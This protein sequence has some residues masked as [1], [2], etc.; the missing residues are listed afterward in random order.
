MIRVLA[1][2]LAF[3]VA[4]PAAAEPSVAAAGLTAMIRKGT[5]SLKE[6]SWCPT[7]AEDANGGFLLHATAETVRS[8]SLNYDNLK[9]VCA[10]WLAA[11][12]KPKSLG[13]LLVTDQDGRELQLS[14]RCE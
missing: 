10:I 11:G 2:L 4:V 13:Y 3:A 6:Q 1:T 8:M 14:R 5:C 7:Y 12:G 9:T